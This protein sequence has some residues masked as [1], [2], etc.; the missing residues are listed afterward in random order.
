MDSPVFWNKTLRG[1]DTLERVGNSEVILPPL[2]LGIRLKG[3]T[4]ISEGFVLLENKQ[5]VTKLC[6]FEKLV[7]NLLSGSIPLEC[8]VCMTLAV[9]GM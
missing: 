9:S 5:K 8:I 1:I 3:K 2:Y 6:P 7:E 4:C